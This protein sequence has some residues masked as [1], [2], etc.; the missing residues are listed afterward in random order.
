MQG[1][2][3]GGITMETL[4]HLVGEYSTGVITVLEMIVAVDVSM[5]MDMTTGT[6]IGLHLNLRPV[7]Q[8][9]LQIMAK[10]YTQLTNHCILLEIKGYPLKRAE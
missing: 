6:M 2:D 7:H 3:I 5:G 9:V 10:Y 4:T 1:R 8:V